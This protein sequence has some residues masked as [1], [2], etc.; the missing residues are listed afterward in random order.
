VAAFAA[1]GSP[2]RERGIRSPKAG[3]KTDFA[4]PAV[5]ASL[6]RASGCDYPLFPPKPNDCDLWV[7]EVK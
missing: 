5:I 6:A 4:T 7:A 3:K 2:K 1:H